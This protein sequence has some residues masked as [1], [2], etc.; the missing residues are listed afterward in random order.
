M[1]LVLYWQSRADSIRSLSSPTHYNS[2]LSRALR[3]PPALSTRLNRKPTAQPAPGSP[4]GKSWLILAAL[5]GS[6]STCQAQQ[7]PWQW[8]AQSAETRSAVLQRLTTDAAGSVYLAGRFTGQIRLGATRLVSQGRSD[9]FVAKLTAG[10]QWAWAVAAGGPESDE[11]TDLAL[12]AQGNLLVAGAF[13]GKASFGSRE[14]VSNGGQ[15][16]F[17]A[18]LTPQGEW[19]GVVTAGGLG[20]DEAYCL[21]A[22]PH[23][24]VVL[25]GRFQ[26]TAEFGAHRLQATAG[27]DGFVAHLDQHGGWAWAAQLGT[28]EEGAVRRVA[29][30]KQGD[31]VVTGY[32][33]GTGQF[34][35]HPLVSQG[36]HN[37]FVAKLSGSGAWQWATGGRSE[38]T[39]Y[40]NAVVLD[41][42][43]RI[44]VTG[45]YSG[46][47]AFG[48]HQLASHGGDDT[49]VA[50][51]SPAGEWQWV[52]SLQGPA[53][54]TGRDLALSPLG[55]LYVV[56]S[57]SPAAACMGATLASHG[58]LDVFLAR[59]TT[60]GKWLNAQAIGSQGTDEGS[61]LAL[62]PTGEALV[63]GTLSLAEPASAIAPQVFVGRF[64]FPVTSSHD[65]Q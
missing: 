21:T 13:G 20:Q 59:L 51:L 53:F 42:Q 16:V 28:T 48:P 38:S 65:L 40:G 24:T 25:G 31:V 44:Y 12:D 56:G 27:N 10:G 11:A 61:A 58:G 55:T 7:A 41:E 36:T 22:G 64:R 6:Y 49:Y 47:V 23:N 50:R 29:V 39:T 18:A 5:V 37:A 46:Q 43:N 17:V 30:D 19:R 34:G 52:T 62:A 8:L 9:T 45:S 54:E 3:L 60:E 4:V 14:V 57:S 15:D 32:L 26:E 33:G 2:M 1:L 35:A 63:G